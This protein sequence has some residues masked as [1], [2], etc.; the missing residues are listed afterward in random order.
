MHQIMHYCV[1][2]WALYKLYGIHVIT[3]TPHYLEACIFEISDTNHLVS[4]EVQWLIDS[5]EHMHTWKSTLVNFKCA[6]DRL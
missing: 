4:R 2:Q 3:E 5:L 1:K 6:V